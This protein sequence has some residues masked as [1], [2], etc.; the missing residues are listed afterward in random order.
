MNEGEINAASQPAR[1]RVSHP[2]EGGFLRRPIHL[3]LD[4]KQ[5]AV[6][7]SGKETIIEI[8]PGH[9]RLRADN[10]FLPKTVEFDVEAGEQV[11]YTTWNRRG[12]GSWM[13]EIFGAGPLYLVIQRV[14][15]DSSRSSEEAPRASS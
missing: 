13:I 6:L 7:S 14:E 11:S 9:H 8:E 3:S 2:D 10:T 5:F 15:G 1:L 4:D 12:F